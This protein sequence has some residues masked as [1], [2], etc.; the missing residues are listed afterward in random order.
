MQDEHLGFW[1]FP[2]FFS[3][4]NNLSTLNQTLIKKYLGKPSSKTFPVGT[5]N[6]TS[7]LTSTTAVDTQQ[8]SKIQTT[9][10]V[11]PN[12]IQSLSQCKNHSINLLDSSNHLWDAPDFRV[13]YDLKVSHIFEHTHPIIIKSTFSFHSV[14]PPPHLFLLR[15]GGGGRGVRLL[16]N[17]QKR[18]ASQDLDF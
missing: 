16:P 8:M 3:T 7:F 11:K 4:G 15:E 5:R 14:H 1:S 6:R 10:V 12:I 9:L 18:G 13:P 2:I 17:F